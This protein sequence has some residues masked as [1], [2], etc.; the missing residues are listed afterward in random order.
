M[1]AWIQGLYRF[2]STG[3]SGSRA[4]QA[5]RQNFAIQGAGE[6]RDLNDEGQFGH[7][8]ITENGHRAK[9]RD[10]APQQIVRG[11]QTQQDRHLRRDE[12]DRR[13]PQHRC[14]GYASAPQPVGDDPEKT[15]AEAQRARHDKKIAADFARCDL[16]D[17]GEPARRPKPL[18]GPCCTDA[19]RRERRDGEVAGVP[20]NLAQTGSVDRPGDRTKSRFDG[21]PR[22]IGHDQEHQRASRD[23]DDRKTDEKPAPAYR[24]DHR[25]A[26]LG[27]HQ[28]PGRA[29]HD[30][31][32][33]EKRQPLLREP[34]SQSLDPRDQRRRDPDPDQSA[35]A[36][37][38]DGMRGPSE[39]KRTNPGD[40]HHRRL[41][42]ARSETVQHNAE[43]K[44][45]AGE[46]KKV[47]R[48]HQAEKT[49]R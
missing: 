32:A 36:K 31:P 38:P 15:G 8:R 30:K 47:R 28:R 44:L 24:I 46:G 41:G 9:H 12:N 16:L 4:V 21:P 17:I 19:G 34:F 5:G 48:G 43:R 33:I 22:R 27:R 39:Q 7:G 14:G 23:R 35:C 10:H 2:K 6:A 13:A 11:R 26:G 37:Q 29:Q 20:E 45:D 1:R 49:R 42:P 40:D 18:Y 25:L 3:R